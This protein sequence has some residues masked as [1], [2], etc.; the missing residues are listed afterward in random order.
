MRDETTKQAAQEYLATRLTEEQERYEAEQNRAI[1]SARSIVVWRR[2]RDSLLAQCRE[3]NTIA[4]EEALKCTET[5]M[6]DLRVSCVSPPRQMTIHFDSRK[7]LVTIKN[8]GRLEHEKDAVLRVEGYRTGPAP[9][10]PRDAHLVRVL[11]DEA[12]NLDMLLL[13]EL[14]VLT[15]MKRQREA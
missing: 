11:N 4:G 6:G 5:L 14:R 15:G 7:L 13:A 3:W 9:D 10:A 8:P 12:V 1:A 2:L